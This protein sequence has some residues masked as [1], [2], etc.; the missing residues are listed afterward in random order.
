MGLLS[1]ERKER[2][3]PGKPGMDP[4]GQAQPLAAPRPGRGSL[5]GHLSSSTEQ[6]VLGQ[7]TWECRGGPRWRSP[8]A[9]YL[10]AGQA[11]PAAPLQGTSHSLHF[12]PGRTEIASNRN[13]KWF[14]N[15]TFMLALS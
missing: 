12:L 3:T 15:L 4:M 2:P 10:P 9:Q 7:S 5:L 8:R 1:T 14:K 13:H 11:Q 6:G